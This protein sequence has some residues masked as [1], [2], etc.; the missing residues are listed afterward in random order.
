M[1]A[2]GQPVVSMSGS[3]APVGYAP[4]PQTNWWMLSGVMIAIGA[5]CIGI[6]FIVLG[7]EIVAT[8]YSPNYEAAFYALL[9]VGIVFI[10]LSWPFA[11]MTP[12][13][14]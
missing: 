2:P 4:P 7:L 8:T 5:L 9:G 12:R 13:M 11:R 10:G 14:R 6:G 1:A 3:A